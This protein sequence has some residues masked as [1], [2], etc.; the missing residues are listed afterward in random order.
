[1][2][3]IKLATPILFCAVILIASGALDLG[4]RNTRVMAN[5]QANN[6]PNPSPSPTEDP[7]LDTRVAVL[8]GSLRDF[9]ALATV[10]V[11][12]VS[13]LVV[14]NVGLSV[15]QVGSLAQ[16]EVE[17]AINKYDAQFHGFLTQRKDLIERRLTEYRD[18]LA[19]MAREF[20]GLE[21]A[22]RRA[23]SIVSSAS[24]EIAARGD[25]VMRRLE[26]TALRMRESIQNNDTTAPNQGTNDTAPEA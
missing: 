4:I 5:T 2:K 17:T 26:K 9:S 21:A 22:A 11:A 8:E 14:A 19:E 12:I 13:M 1:M 7:A 24:Y 10:F 15:W 20:E 25:D 16:R 6:A 18:T 23:E 3:R